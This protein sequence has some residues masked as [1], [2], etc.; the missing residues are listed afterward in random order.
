MD[1]AMNK[2]VADL[3]DEGYVLLNDYEDRLAVFEK[4]G[5]AEEISEWPHLLVRAENGEIFE[6]WGAGLTRFSPRT[7]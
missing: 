7:R 1:D 4:L 3:L 5:M 6:V 2:T